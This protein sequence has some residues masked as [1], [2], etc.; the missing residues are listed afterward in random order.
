MKTL[1]SKL[2]GTWNYY[3]LI[4]NYRRLKLYYEATCRTVYK[5]L[6]RRSQR[7]KITWPAF[8]GMLVRFQVPEPRI[9]EKQRERMPCQ[10]ELSFCQRLMSF[11]KPKANQEA[12]ASA[13]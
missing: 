3:G 11:L 5:W 8:A 7:K 1:A 2:R 9:V 13:S 4:G 12:Y 10:M 6:T